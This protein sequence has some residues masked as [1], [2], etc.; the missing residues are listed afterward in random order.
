MTP[1]KL[2]GRALSRK[3]TRITLDRFVAAHA[4]TGR[5]LDLGSQAGPYAALFPHRVSLDMARGPGVQVIGDAQALGI[6]DGA[7]EVVLCT[8]MLEHLPEPQRGLDEIY[9]V[10]APGGTLVLTT[11]FL[12]PVH[13]APHDYFRFTKFGLRYLLR[14]FEHVEVVEESTAV[15]SLA[16]L[17][18]RMGMQAETLGWTPLRAIW[19]I[20]AQPLRLFS[21]LITK[22][23]GDSRRRSVETGVFTSGYHVVC[24]KPA[25]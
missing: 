14:R 15:G 2:I 21:F 18:Q 10:L 17:V 13:D 9:R 1:T 3:L 23:Y 19:L 24:R 16:I 25:A 7:F 11:R 12:F 22:Q 4:S 8:E 6:L 5:T 20:A